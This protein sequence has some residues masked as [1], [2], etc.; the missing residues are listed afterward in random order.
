M[1]LRLII[2]FLFISACSNST[3]FKSEPKINSEAKKLGL[4]R[5]GVSL[6]FYN[7]NKINVATLPKVDEIKKKN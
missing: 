2:L 3:G 1:S 7:L 5:N 6:K 4:E